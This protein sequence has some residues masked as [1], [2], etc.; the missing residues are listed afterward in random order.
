MKLK[1]KWI[2]DV[3]V[4]CK[5]VKHLENNISPKSIYKLKWNIKNIEK[6]PKKV[7]KEEQSN[8]IKWET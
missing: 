1:S 4:I 8:K 5:T 2:M 7:G 3:N 6:N